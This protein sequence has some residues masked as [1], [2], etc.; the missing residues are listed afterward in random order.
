MEPEPAPVGTHHG[1]L[2]ISMCMWS[3]CRLIDAAA[4]TPAAWPCIP[5]SRLP[6]VVGYG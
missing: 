3:C 4:A 2:H 5:A 6:A 1:R